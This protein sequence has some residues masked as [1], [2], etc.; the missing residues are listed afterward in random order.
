MGARKSDKNVFRPVLIES[1]QKQLA[2]PQDSVCIRKNGIEFFSPDPF[3]QWVEMTV[4]LKAPQD[5]KKV[6]CQGVVVACDGNIHQGFAVSMLFTSMSRQ[7][8]SVLQTI[9]FEQ[10]A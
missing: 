3:P 2:L 4:E 8:E 1:R 9:A 5:G 10:V 7:S 6:R